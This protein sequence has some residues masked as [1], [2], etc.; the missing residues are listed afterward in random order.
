MAFISRKSLNSV[1]W[2]T[3]TFTR[4]GGTMSSDAPSR[5]FR[6]SSIEDDGDKEGIAGAARDR[7]VEDVSSL[8]ADMYEGP[9]A[10]L[11]AVGA[12]MALLAT[13]MFVLAFGRQ[14]RRPDVG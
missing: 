11:A 14:P 7:L 10:A 9:F 8:R 2:D 4:E 12:V 6:G 1:G 5:G 13:V 3:E